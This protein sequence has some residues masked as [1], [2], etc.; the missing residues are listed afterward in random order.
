MSAE[1]SGP[2][3]RLGR[4]RPTAGAVATIEPTERARRCLHEGPV[5]RQRVRDRDWGE[6]YVMPH[7]SL[8]CSAATPAMTMAGKRVKSIQTGAMAGNIKLT[9]L[10]GYAT[11]PAGTEES[12]TAA[13]MYFGCRFAMRALIRG[14]D[15]RCIT[16]RFARIAEA[17]SRAKGRS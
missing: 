6:R 15:P 8:C 3:L 17:V 9:G 14:D 7:E 13:L 12:R 16:P 1:V 10:R 4:G 2:A 11:L 5:R